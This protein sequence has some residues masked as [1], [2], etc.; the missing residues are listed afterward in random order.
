LTRLFVPA[1]DPGLR[2]GTNL[3]RARFDLIEV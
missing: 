2:P 3:R 1:N